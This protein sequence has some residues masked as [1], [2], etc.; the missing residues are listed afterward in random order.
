MRAATILARLL[1]LIISKAVASRRQGCI[2]HKMRL[3]FVGNTIRSA[4]NIGL[5]RNAHV[6][7]HV[8][9]SLLSL[10]F[11]QNWNEFTEDSK[12]S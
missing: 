3:P 7:I 5:A 4:I 12:T 8:T 10:V 6:G 2:R 11:N 1:A 9:C